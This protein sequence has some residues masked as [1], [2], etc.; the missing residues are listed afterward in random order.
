MVKWNDGVF[1]PAYFP[2]WVDTEF[3]CPDCG[4]VMQKNQTVVLTSN[5][6]QYL[7]KCKECGEVRYRWQ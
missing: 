2:E 7:Y 5:P 3:E 1:T 6:P 4:G